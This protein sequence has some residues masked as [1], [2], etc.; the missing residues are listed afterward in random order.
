MIKNKWIYALVVLLATACQQEILDVT[1]PR[2]DFSVVPDYADQV[3]GQL[4]VKFR[5][6]SQDLVVT[7]TATGLETDSRELTDAVNR[8][9]G[10]RMERLFPYAGKFEARTRKAGLHLWYK[11]YFDEK[12]NPDVATRVLSGVPEI[13]T[14][15][16]VCIPTSHAVPFP[17]NDS[18]FGKQWYLRYAGSELESERGPLEMTSDIDVVEA[19]EIERGKP[20]V[21]VAVVDSKVDVGHPELQSN[22]W[23]NDKERDGRPDVDDD[24]NGYVD[25]VYGYGV[26]D[27]Q[28]ADKHGT[29]VA[30]II[31]AKNN[32]DI[33]NPWSPG[34]I[35]GIAGGDARLGQDGVRIMAC[36][37]NNPVVA[38]KYAADHDAVICTNSW[39]VKAIEQNRSSLQEVVNYFTEYAGIDENGVQTGPMRGGLVLASAGN[40]GEEFEAVYPA[41]L[42][43]VFAVAALRYDMKKADYSNYASW[44][45]ISAPGGEGGN[46]G[47]YSLLN[48]ENYMYNN[49]FGYLAGTSM[50]TPVVTGVAAL[51]VSK[52]GG[53]G[54][55]L[56]PY[57]VTYRLQHG[58]KPVDE[59]NP[60]YAGKLGAGCVNALRALQIGADE[61]NYPPVV[62]CNKE[63][64]KTGIFY[65][66]DRDEYE[67]TISER[68]GEEMTYTV[69]DPTG[70]VSHC[71]NGEKIV[72]V[73]NNRNC[74]AGDQVITLTV[75][76]ASDLS[77][78]VKIPVKLLPE[79]LKEV[80]IESSVVDKLTVRASM[81]F[82]GA[83]KVELYDA[84]GN[85]VLQDK[86]TI[87]LKE[88]GELDLSGVDGGNYVLKLTCNNKTITKNIIKL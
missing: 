25:D 84:S 45:D 65:Y 75:T 57:D 5:E 32:N 26:R 82:S 17:Y 69:D 87:S 12:V 63:L 30:G 13:M 35:C 61:I 62:T 73:L 4:Q 81:T 37:F 71:R 49:S 1:V 74:K 11:V 56:T 79:P 55:G 88:P 51:I 21:I 19:W 29:H 40:E 38:I 64:K 85:L 9:G 66:G 67:F 24:G 60:E 36:L 53:E 28:D 31:G 42:D 39:G 70:A 23:V 3:K 10:V 20:E 59:A 22:L 77:T 7:P 6:L 80:E 43:N 76:D 41:S 14:V 44:V 27:Q 78:V 34:F 83:V 52:F 58:V 48:G 50:A 47:I 33:G 54:S 46:T 72:L 16:P 15:E 2:D 8:I 18:R 86:M 68:D